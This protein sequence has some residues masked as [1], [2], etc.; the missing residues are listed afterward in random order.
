MDG[1][2]GIVFTPSKIVELMLDT[3]P[4]HVWSDTSIRFF[5]PCAGYGQF[6]VAIY[7]R[8]MIG[9]EKVIPSEK[10]RKRHILTKM[11]FMAELNKEFAGICR[12]ALDPKSE[13]DL[14]LFQGD[15]LKMVWKFQF[16]VILGNPPYNSGSQPLYHHFVSH[17]WDKSRYLLF[18]IPSRWMS[19]GRG[20]DQ[21]RSEMLAKKDVRFIRHEVNSRLVFPDVDISGGVCFFLKDAEYSGMCKFNGGSVAMDR[22]DVL[23]EKKYHTLIDRLMNEP[24]LTEIYAGR[25]FGIESNDAR[26]LDKKCKGAIKCYVSQMKGFEKWVKMEPDGLW[27]VITARAVGDTRRLGNT[28]VGK[29]DEA[30]TGSYLSFRVQS[31]REAKSLLSY[32]KCE[33]ANCMLKLRLNS[34][35][36]SKSSFAWIPLPALDREWNDTAV[37]KYYGVEV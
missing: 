24:K 16:D 35:N 18:I 33:L 1:S 17:F 9:L 27:K 10:K 22:Y 29:P 2:K 21:F 19:G 25:C 37:N 26:L 5:D 32:L 36:M 31:E 30:H 4:P 15:S 6:P 7:R 20:L 8:L 23:V 13:Y 28:F 11:L 3:L 14:K 34:H 12:K